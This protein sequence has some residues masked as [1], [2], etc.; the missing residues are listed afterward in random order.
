MEQTVLRFIVRDFDGAQL[1]AHER[2]LQRL[3]DEVGAK[4]PRARITVEVAR[5]YRNM[6]EYLTPHPRASTR[7]RSPCAGPG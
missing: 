1:E 4:E 3:A 5:S 6:K 7:P 2:L